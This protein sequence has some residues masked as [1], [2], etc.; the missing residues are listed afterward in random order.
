MEGGY[1][2]WPGH[3]HA[4]GVGPG[5]W[6]RQAAHPLPTH[7]LPGRES[8]TVLQRAS[9]PRLRFQYGTLTPVLSYRRPLNSCCFAVKTISINCEETPLL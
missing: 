1:G 9:A 6:P 2:S 4:L 7:L 3:L 8:R 5:H